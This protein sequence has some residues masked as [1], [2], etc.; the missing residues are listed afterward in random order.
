MFDNLSLD[1]ILS[2]LKQHDRDLYD[3]AW[4]VKGFAPDKDLRQSL[5][6]VYLNRQKRKQQEL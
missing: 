2:Y 3:R 6:D 1:E 5:I 4:V